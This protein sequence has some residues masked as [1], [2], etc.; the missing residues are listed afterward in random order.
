ML[1]DREGIPSALQGTAD[2]ERTQL[3]LTLRSEQDYTSIQDLFERMPEES[4]SLKIEI[5]FKK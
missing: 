4:T 2:I 3:S 1:P 5:K